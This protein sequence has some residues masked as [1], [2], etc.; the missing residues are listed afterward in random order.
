MNSPLEA[1][2]QDLD[3]L[4]QWTLISLDVYTNYDVDMHVNM[5]GS[6]EIVK[7]VKIRHFVEIYFRKILM[8]ARLLWAYHRY[9]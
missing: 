4:Q 6:I 2:N 9:Y 3:V 7:I 1:M 8:V 5:V